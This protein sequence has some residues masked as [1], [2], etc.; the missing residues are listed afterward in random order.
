[1]M[2]NTKSLPIE[3]NGRFYNYSSE[4][5][6]S[7]V[8][9]SLIM[10]L[11][12]LI[13]RNLFHAKVEYKAFQSSDSIL[14]K[15]KDLEITWVG[16]STLFI[17]IGEINILTDPVFGNLTS[18]FQRILPPGIEFAQLPSID[19]VIISHNHRD[20][21]DL[22]SIKLLNNHKK[23]IFLV[24]LGLKKWFEKHNIYNVYEYNWWQQSSFNLESIINFTFLPAFHWSSRNLFDYNKTLWGSWM[25]ECNGKK[26]YFA[27]DT[28]Y[29]GHFKVIG[30]EFSDID[31][32]C[33]PIG[34]C[35]PHKWMKSSHVNAEEAGQGFVDLKARHFVPIHWGT[36]YFGIDKFQDPLNR[37]SI[38]FEHICKQYPNLKLHKLKIGQRIGFNI[39]PDIS[40]SKIKENPFLEI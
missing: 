18:I 12:S 24:P 22:D 20:H 25:I 21:L 26:I 1:M 15:S 14:Q 11:K 5:K 10:L 16:H 7:I 4:R 17:Q 6:K 3:K 39:D 19:F 38:W 40:Y 13:A 30:Q 23:I 32:A 29:A 27:G 28:A 35:E 33:M 36:F 9:P 2:L 8:I 31:V 34:P 37:I